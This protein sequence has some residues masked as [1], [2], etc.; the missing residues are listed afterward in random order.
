MDC[1]FSNE[2]KSTNKLLQRLIFYEWYDFHLK[3][4]RLIA[5][6]N[7]YGAYDVLPSNEPP[8]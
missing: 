2:D 1:Y 3:K 4:Q 6:L 8:L 7:L 5:S